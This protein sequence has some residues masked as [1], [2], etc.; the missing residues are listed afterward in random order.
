M[1][2]LYEC[3][4]NG[5]F[6]SPLGEFDSSLVRWTSTRDF[7]KHI[8]VDKFPASTLTEVKSD[9]RISYKEL[10]EE[11]QSVTDQLSRD[12]VRPRSVIHLMGETSL[13]WLAVFLGSHLSDCIISGTHPKAP[14][15]ELNRNIT[16][17]CATILVMSRSCYSR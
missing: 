6:H 2:P 15:P 16:T 3:D 17:T 8:F 11:G 7:F 4:K 5:V 14:W 1:P 9:C 13:Q 10:F 12:G